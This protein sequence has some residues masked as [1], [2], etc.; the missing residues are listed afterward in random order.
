MR[1]HLTLSWIALLIQVEPSCAS[2]C[3][4]AIDRMQA[5]IDAGLESA[6]ARGKTAKQS[7]GAQLDHQPTPASIAAA[8]AALNEGRKYQLALDDLSLARTRDQLNDAAGCKAALRK[9]KHDLR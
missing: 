1:T 2:P 6:A 5:R 9:V 7:T 3:S 8:E 4:R